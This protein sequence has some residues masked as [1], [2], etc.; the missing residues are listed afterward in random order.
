MVRQSGNIL[1]VLCG[2]WLVAQAWT[3]ACAAADNL[4][5][6]EP[7]ASAAKEPAKYTVRKG[8]LRI[9]VTLDGAFESREMSEVILRPEAW[10]ELVVREAAAPGT[11]VKA[12]D[13]I[14]KL[15]ATKL[16]EAIKALEAS[17]RLGELTR[18]QNEAELAAL[19]QT[20]PLDLQAAERAKQSAETDLKHFLEVDREMQTRSA[21][22]SLRS[23]KNR[24]EYSESELQ[25]LEKMYK[26][27]DLTEETEE[28][29]LKRQR[30]EVEAARFSLEQAKVF[31]EQ[32]LKVT[33]PRKEETLQ[34]AAR[35]TVLALEKSQFSTPL[36]TTTSKLELDK[37][38]VDHAKSTER[39]EKLRQDLSLMSVRAPRAGVVYYGASKHGQWATGATVAARLERGGAVAA[40]EVLMTIVAPEALAVWAAVP[41]KHLHQLQVGQQ[42]IA[43]PTGY[44]G[45]RMVVKVEQAPMYPD[46]AGKYWV[47]AA[48]DARRQAGKDRGPVAGMTCSLAINCYNKPD[49]LTVPAAAVQMDDGSDA[50]Y[51]FVVGV[52]GKAARRDIQT[53]RRSDDRVEVTGGINDGE[54][55]LVGRP[56]GL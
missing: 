36:K 33:I 54:M 46:A 56:E 32:A 9:D 48:V 12:G 25:Q 10:S 39:L 44:P 4:S 13:V 11:A 29:I 21:D 17:L 18:R 50:S 37:V 8:P 6:S 23:S 26:A 27:D 55:V 20:A 16:E 49:A 43:A 22:F 24:L 40:N 5:P 51:V 1:C 45:D 19:E 52:D 31:H 35:R 14:L 15:D 41:E 42:G 47:L 34:D 38:Q 30:E 2:A 53:G 3:G 7:V 28:I